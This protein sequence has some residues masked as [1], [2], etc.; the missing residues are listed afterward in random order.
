VVN[1]D[2]EYWRTLAEERQRQIDLLR[3]RLMAALEAIPDPRLRASIAS[4][5]GAMS[6]WLRELNAMPRTAAVENAEV[7]DVLEDLWRRVA[8]DAR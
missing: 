2:V 6:A 7:V 8:D 5:R 4:R 1:E 3:E